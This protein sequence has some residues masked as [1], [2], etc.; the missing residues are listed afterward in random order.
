MLLLAMTYVCYMLE[1]VLSIR[2]HFFM[3]FFEL[4]PGYYP[5]NSLVA[6]FFNILHYKIQNISTVFR[7]FTFKL[8][9]LE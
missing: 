1:A 4:I 5:K 6:V 8:N 7:I 3:P 2:N 9:F